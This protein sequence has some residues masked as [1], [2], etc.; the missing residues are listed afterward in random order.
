M[1]RIIVLTKKWGRNFTGATLA[2]QY[3]VEQWLK[4]VEQIHVFTLET[5]LFTNN[6]KLIIHIYGNESDIRKQVSLFW[7]S[8][9][10]KS[11]VGYS[12]DHL[13]Y[14]LSEAGIPY[15]HTYHGNWPDA[16]LISF[17][18]FL[19]SFYFIPLYKKTFRGAQKVINVSRYMELY[20]RRFNLDSMVI[21]NGLDIKE[22][23]LE[24]KFDKTFLMVGNIDKRKYGCAIKVAKE[25]LK[26]TPEIKIHI[27]GKKLDVKVAKQLK[28]LSNIK[29]M[30]E[31]KNIPY[32]AYIGFINTSKIENLSISV[33]EA[34]MNQIPVF[35]FSVGGLTE[36]VEDKKTGYVFKTYDISGMADSISKYAF[37]EER[38]YIDKNILKDFDWNFAAAKYLEVFNQIK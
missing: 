2:T 28:Q 38:A 21:H 34:I 6:S 31:K 5:G 32:K 19:K 3:Y 35:C 9:D 23:S 26:K 13:G 7:N 8:C 30:G 16:R 20:T 14:L 18:Y 36:V 12:D 17:G 37:N 11:H 15:I 33:C 1:K 25:L 10:K 27:Y 24:K 4:S 22:S 29:L